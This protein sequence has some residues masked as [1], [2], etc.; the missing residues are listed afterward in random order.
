M[1]RCSFAIDGQERCVSDFVDA[2]AIADGV[3][4]GSLQRVGHETQR[5]EEVALAGAV[6]ADEKGQ[7]AQAH[8]APT[9]AAVVLQPDAKQE[10]GHG[11]V[12]NPVE[13][14]PSRPAVPAAGLQ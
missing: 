2:A 11:A 14:D 8:V 6:R 9:D 4:Q 7:R 12:Q 13:R 3:I 10:R 5:V 1:S